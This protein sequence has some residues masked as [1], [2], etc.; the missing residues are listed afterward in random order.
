MSDSTTQSVKKQDI[1]VTRVFDVPV[2]Q[3]W[4]AWVDP[5]LVMQWWGP[6]GF[7]SP[8]AQMD[9]REG[10]T[11]LVCMRPPK[12]FGNQD[13]YNTWTYTKIVPN[14]MIEFIQN[15][16]DKDGKLIDP[17]TVGMPPDFPRDMRSVV[18]FKSMGSQ[19]E[20]TATEYD[21]TPGQMMEFSKLGLEQ[22]L[23][24][25]KAALKAGVE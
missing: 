14:E 1:V 6:D 18:A 8:S 12:E 17:V 16:S 20:L 9:F 22:C 13:F 7:T 5:Q 24:K 19:T 11:S 23:D 21:W 2:E 25:M 15:L 10:G 3:V 4:R